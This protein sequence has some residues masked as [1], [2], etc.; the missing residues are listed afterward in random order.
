[1]L[2]P[3]SALEGWI[4]GQTVAPNGA[5]VRLR[6]ITGLELIQLGFWPDTQNLVAE[7]LKARIGTGIPED[8]RAAAGT[9]NI[10]VMRIAPLKIWIS[11]QR[12]GGLAGTIG[13]AVGTEAAA[14]T[15]L[16]HART[17]LQ[18]DG[19]AAAD[20]VRRLITIDIHET[21]FPPGS[22][23]QTG[24]CGVGVLLHAVETESNEVAY[25]LYLPRSFALA[26]SDY[27]AKVA[28]PFGCWTAG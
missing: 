12:E 26:L 1:M 8:H 28:A 4:N 2:E 13:A 17:I 23:A 20:V 15:D 27:V 5:R 19:R 25:N 9:G 11:G 22:F 21:V 18:I 6:E 24:L 16:S 14:I 10:C 7:R 3:R